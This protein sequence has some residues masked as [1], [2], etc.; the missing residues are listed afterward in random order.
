M[1]FVRC[2]LAC[3]EEACSTE[4]EVRGVMVPT[5]AGTHLGVEPPDG[6]TQSPLT[7]R[8]LCPSCSRQ[9]AAQPAASRGE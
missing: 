3:D 6:W 8:H 2:V 7:Q 9:P 5:A 4:A 1:I